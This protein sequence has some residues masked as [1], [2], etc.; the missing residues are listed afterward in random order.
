MLFRNKN[1]YFK[2]M[3]ADFHPETF[4]S[5]VES[6]ATISDRKKI[7]KEILDTT[8]FHFK[9]YPNSLEIIKTCIDLGA[10]PDSVS[11]FAIEHV[12]E[13]KENNVFNILPPTSTTNLEICIRTDNL[14]M[15]R[16]HLDRGVREEWLPTFFEYTKSVE[17]AKMLVEEYNYPY[18][19]KNLCIVFIHDIQIL[20]YLLSREDNNFKKSLKNSI[21]YCTR[22]NQVHFLQKHLGHARYKNRWNALYKKCVDTFN[23]SIKFNFFFENFYEIIDYLLDELIVN[24]NTIKIENAALQAKANTHS[25]FQN[26]F[27]LFILTTTTTTTMTGSSF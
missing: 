1:R 10:D 8:L 14:E 13:L 12:L 3:L 26:T 9:R 19:K 25:Q 7:L 15:T 4:H 24:S 27:F 5:F 23:R 22:I 17:M 11:D 2:E 16:F 21:I 6:F 20:E 18:F